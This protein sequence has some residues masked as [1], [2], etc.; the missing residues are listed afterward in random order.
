ML[1]CDSL[2]DE[3]RGEEDN[4]MP[5]SLVAYDD[6][7]GVTPPA[8][9]VN[10]APSNAYVSASAKAAAEGSDN[11]ASSAKGDRRLISK[12]ASVPHG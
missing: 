1:L 10:I 8:V 11:G 6:D 9:S 5:V 2:T 3:E 4:A 7:R 12:G